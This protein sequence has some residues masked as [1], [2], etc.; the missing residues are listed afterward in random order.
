MP[1]RLLLEHSTD[2]GIFNLIS[3]RFFE[4]QGIFHSSSSV[5]C[6]G[7]GN[8]NLANIG[9]FPGSKN[10]V[11]SAVPNISCE[12]KKVNFSPKSCSGV[13]LVSGLPE[14]AFLLC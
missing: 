11:L 7:M 10:L 5:N 1:F 13:L 14:L 2:S 6:I 3:S 8:P 9:Y 12:E 4:S